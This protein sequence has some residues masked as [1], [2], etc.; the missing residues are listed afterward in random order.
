MSEQKTSEK[1]PHKG[2]LDE[3][4]SHCDGD[5][6]CWE[7]RYQVVTRDNL[8]DLQVAV[9]CFIHQKGWKPL[10]GVSAVYRTWENERKGYTE[11]D[12]M[13]AQAMARHV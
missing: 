11:S 6:W 5:C 3:D 8:D 9:N 10:G 2:T 7:D 4:G 1:R 12:M 13:W